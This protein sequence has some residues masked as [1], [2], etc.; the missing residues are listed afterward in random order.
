MG[1]E[2]IQP[3]SAS[4]VCE[5]P[6]A[7]EPVSQRTAL[8]GHDVETASPD[9]F[10]RRI[11]EGIARFRRSL[12]SLVNALP[13]FSRVKA[14]SPARS[15]RRLLVSLL[16]GLGPSTVNHA[17]LGVELNKLADGKQRWMQQDPEHG[18]QQFAEMVRG[19]LDER[20]PGKKALPL[21]E[22]VG[23]MAGP[24]FPDLPQ[25]PLCE[26]LAALVRAKAG[27]YRATEVLKA[28]HQNEIRRMGFEVAKHTAEHIF[29]KGPVLSAALKAFDKASQAC[30]YQ[31]GATAE[32]LRIA[33]DTLEEAGNHLLAALE[34][35]H[36]RK[37]GRALGSRLYANQNLA[38]FYIKARNQ[39]QANLYDQF[40]DNYVGPAPSS[41]AIVEK[42]SQARAL[43][44]QIAR[45]GP[46]RLRGAPRGAEERY[47]L[48]L[49]KK[50]PYLERVSSIEAPDGDADMKA[51]RDA[52][53]R[54]PTTISGR[55]KSPGGAAP[56]Y[57]DA[58]E[59][60]NQVVAAAD[61]KVA[62]LVAETVE[63]IGQLGQERATPERARNAQQLV[64]ATNSA[65]LGKLP[66]NEQM[67]LMKLI[68]G[69]LEKRPATTK[70]WRTFLDAQE[71]LC[72]A[73]G[74]R[75]E[76]LAHEKQLRR[77]V[78]NKLGEHKE[79]L[80]NA[81]D[82]WHTYTPQQQRALLKKIASVH[83]EALGCEPP[84]DIVFDSA[85]HGCLWMHDDRRIVIGS[86]G[87]CHM[88]FELTM[89]CLFHEN[90]H[91]WQD[92]LVRGLTGKDSAHDPLHEQALIFKANLPFYSQPRW[93]YFQ[94]RLQPVEAHAYRSG[95]LLAADL[96]RM[97]AS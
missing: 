2:T 82:L 18:E 91:N 8:P 25:A 4:T 62:V 57:G 44:A 74:L 36:A 45:D 67:T 94:Y 23:A 90:T 58:L 79:M 68:C 54:L 49:R 63:K 33:R 64:L 14:D 71:R 20:W 53:D 1:W 11:S 76:L 15:T 96:M 9:G 51:L 55:E 3:K 19:V 21:E 6:P 13:G 29:L 26:Q 41:A 97:L 34:S 95:R 47:F 84:R 83:C 80:R 27:D 39:A 88:D 66:V 85:E 16:D 89:A 37:A 92:Q 46:Q 17:K 70:K 59:V 73:M 35:T 56:D 43:R 50:F 10:R 7:A 93:G 65:V 81:R 22:A 28:N 40:C 60:L 38:T 42:A 52:L 75:P 5:L 78:T 31:P 69:N 86:A 87:G 24:G 72:R 32:E 48:A 12:S 77:D 61:R 30:R